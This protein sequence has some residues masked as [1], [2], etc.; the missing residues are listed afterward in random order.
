[1]YGLGVVVGVVVRVGSG[2]G[3]VYEVTGGLYVGVGVDGFGDADGAGT[4][5]VGVAVGCFAGA[6]GNSV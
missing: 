6:F 2:L 3:G 4:Y 1:V 5:G